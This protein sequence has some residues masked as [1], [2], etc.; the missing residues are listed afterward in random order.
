MIADNLLLRP[1]ARILALGGDAV[2]SIDLGGNGGAGSGGTVILRVKSSLTIA[3]GAVIV[4]AGGVANQAVPIDPGQGLPLYEGNFHRSEEGVPGFFG[5]VGGNGAPGRI[6]IE[7]DVE[8][9]ASMNGLNSSLSS[10]KFLIDTFRTIAVSRP[11]LLGV[12]PGGSVSASNLLLSGGIV[13]F[14]DFGQPLGTD[15]VV[16]WEGADE[17]LNVHGEVGSFTQRVRDPRDLRFS[18][19]IRFS[20]PLLSNASSRESQSVREILMFYRYPVRV[21]VGCDL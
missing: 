19:Y 6:L 8:S 2:Q 20:V 18:E 15:S 1:E 10:G 4:V 14:H 21:E 11:I 16:L 12:G 7:A 3:P 9:Q 5:G 13:R 17:S